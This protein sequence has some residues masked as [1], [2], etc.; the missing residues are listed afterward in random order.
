MMSEDLNNNNNNYN[1]NVTCLHFYFG[2]VLDCGSHKNNQQIKPTTTDN[3][4]KTIR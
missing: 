4:D 2:L 1:D 3:D